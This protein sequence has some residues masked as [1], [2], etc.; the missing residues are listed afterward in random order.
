MEDISVRQPR[1][2]R[3]LHKVE[4]FFI[5]DSKSRG[6]ADEVIYLLFFV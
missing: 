4:F 3:K 5:K 2:V 6:G 1:S